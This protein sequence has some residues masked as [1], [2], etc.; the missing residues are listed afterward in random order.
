MESPNWELRAL[1]ESHAPYI[2]DSKLVYIYHFQTLD[3]PELV[4][5]FS[6]S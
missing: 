3:K 6:R 5:T 2:T 1:I 4:K